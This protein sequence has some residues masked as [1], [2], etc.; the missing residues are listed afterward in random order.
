MATQAKSASKD[1]RLLVPYSA[2][3]GVLEKKFGDV[4]KLDPDDERTQL[5]LEAGTIGEGDKAVDE[6][7]KGF[8]AN[9]SGAMVPSGTKFVDDGGQPV[10]SAGGVAP[11]EPIDQAKADEQVAAVAT[12]DVPPAL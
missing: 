1:Y 7:R 3:F 8:V 12:P 9:Q 11:G 10:A 6:A 4:V 5:M 2:A